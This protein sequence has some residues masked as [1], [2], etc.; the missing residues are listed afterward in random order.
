MTA[1]SS[2][3]TTARSRPVLP[4]MAPLR[5]GCDPTH[6]FSHLLSCVLSLRAKVKHFMQDHVPC[7]TTQECRSFSG[8]GDLRRFH[9]FTPLVTSPTSSLSGGVGPLPCGDVVRD[10]SANR[11]CDF[12]RV[13]LLRLPLTRCLS[14]QE[15]GLH[16]VRFFGLRVCVFIAHHMP[17]KLAAHIIGSCKVSLYLDVA[18]HSFLPPSPRCKSVCASMYSLVAMLLPRVHAR[19]GNSVDTIAEKNNATDASVL[20]G[21]RSSADLGTLQGLRHPR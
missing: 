17:G 21:C 5:E 6:F 12:G 20:L 14:T 7:R 3:S 18:T 19:D 1:P 13:R 2:S 15:G 16:L 10:G 11:T 9:A 4:I 8:Q